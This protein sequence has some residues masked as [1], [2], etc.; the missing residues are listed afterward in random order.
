[1]LQDPGGQIQVLMRQKYTVTHDQ[2]ENVVL[3]MWVIDHIMFSGLPCP[4]TELSKREE[5][6]KIGAQV[7]KREE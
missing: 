7:R 2:E 5:D 3:W 4:T 1:M 6:K